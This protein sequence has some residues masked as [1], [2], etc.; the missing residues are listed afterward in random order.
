[1]AELKPWLP[2]ILPLLVVELIMKTIALRDLWRRE[3][4]KGNKWLWTGIILFVSLF[5][6]IS[7]LLLGRED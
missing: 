1:M 6:P 2:L 4:V 7:Y 5:G 3:K